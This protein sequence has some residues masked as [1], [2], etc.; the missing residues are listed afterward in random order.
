MCHITS[1]FRTTD[2]HAA[3]EE[4]MAYTAGE[5]TFKLEAT[6]PVGTRFLVR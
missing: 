4:G 1:R 3:G 6:D 5:H 2:Y